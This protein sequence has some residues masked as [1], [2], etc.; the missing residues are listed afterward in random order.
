MA[1]YRKITIEILGG[2]ESSKNDSFKKGISED[3]SEN[4]S[5][6]VEKIFHP[7]KT[8][9][10]A[11]VGK[12]VIANQFYQQ[13]KANFW[14]GIDYYHNR[15]FT[16]GEDYLG[17]MNYSNTKAIFNKAKNYAS[18][19]IGGFMTGTTLSGGNPLVGI[20]TAGL[21]VGGQTINDIFTY[22]E[23]MSGYY[24]SLNA[25]NTQLKFSRQRAGLY[26]E[27]R[28]TEN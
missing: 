26:N 21:S 23:R 19:A 20:I 9:E 2:S 27:G 14:T 18:S 11:T 6:T 24:Q 13:I 4:L 16:L 3:A 12:S 22:K 15:Y 17:Q 7:V 8:L 1:D 25:T 28:G 10:A 5:K